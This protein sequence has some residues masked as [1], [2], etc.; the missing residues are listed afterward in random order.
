MK[1]IGLIAGMSYE[2]SLHYYER[3]NH[4]VNEIAGNLT[5]AKM[6]IYNVNFEEIRV[7]MLNNE[8]DKIAII[9][10]EIAKTLEQA[11]ADYI[12]IATNTMHKLADYVQSKINVPLI[13]IADCV[14][15]KCKESN[16]LN[17]GLL[18]TKYT[19]VEDFLKN[20]L[21]NNGLIVNTP[22]DERIINEIDRIIFD[23]LCKGII[24]DSSREY[25]INVINQMINEYGINGVIFGCTEIEMLVKQHNLDIPIFD[26]TQAHIDKLVDYSLEKVY[27]KK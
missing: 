7:L 15:D 24:K 1:T 9:L 6:I 19:M 20:R 8:W 18:G 10:A 3:I 16:V 12:A 25:Y 21:R 14:A 5:C 26:T 27:I 11:G 4:Q 22:K 13:H 23:E 17:V 2:S